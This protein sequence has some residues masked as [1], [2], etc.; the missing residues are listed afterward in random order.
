MK[1][2]EDAYRSRLSCIILDNL[3]RLIEWVDVG[4]RLSNPILQTILVLLN[5]IPKKA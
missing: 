3:L 2:F 1:I 5:K 4:M